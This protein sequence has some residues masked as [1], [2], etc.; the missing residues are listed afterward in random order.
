[1]VHTVDIGAG[2]IPGTEHG[3][4]GLKKLLF[5]IGG[6]VLAKLLF[7]LGL[8]LFC[9][10][11]KILG[12]KFH[13]KG[14]ALAC[15]HFVDELFKIFLAHFHD[16]VG[17]HLDE[18]PVAVPGPA[19]VVG[20]F[21]ND[22]NYVFVK[23]QIQNGIHHAGH[24]CAG[25]GTDGNQQ[26]VLLIAELL[27][28]DLFHLGNVVHDLTLDFFVDP[29]AVLIVLGAGLGGD[30]E[31]LRNRQPN[32]G[33]FGQVRTFAAQKVA[34]VFGTFG[35]QVNIFVCHSSYLLE[36]VLAYILSNNQFII[37]MHMFLCKR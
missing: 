11:M 13:V 17:E 35:E 33:H 6:E 10:F 14:D 22:P 32:V 34:H 36:N 18:P 26:G 8:E 4:D 23:T 29:A 31:S 2:V 37:A 7:V 30:S 15:L 27:T 20:F 16:H 9:Q 12:G 5:G 25:A 28:S 21:G 3:L 1:M 24:G 19:G